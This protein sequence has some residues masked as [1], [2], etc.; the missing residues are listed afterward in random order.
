MP[1]SPRNVL[2]VYAYLLAQRQ[3]GLDQGQEQQPPSDM[4]PYTLSESAYLTRRKALLQTETHVLRILGFETHVALPY[5]LAINYLQAL[6]VYNNGAAQAQ[7][8]TDLS[9]RTIAHLT[10]AL[11]S[12]QLLYLTQQPPVLATAAIYLAAREM[13]V[14]LPSDEQWWVV[15]DVEREELGFVVVALLSMNAWARGE[16]GMWKGRGRSLPLTVDAIEDEI[17]RTRTETERGERED[18]E[19]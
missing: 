1:Q 8:T 16:W 9:R 13:G 14:K 17:L 10:A 15:F 4:E 18:L 3:D 12:P 5:T 2:N 11:F 7:T 6:D 19:P